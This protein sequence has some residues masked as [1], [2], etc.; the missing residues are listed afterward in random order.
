[1]LLIYYVKYLAGAQTL[2]DAHGTQTSSSAGEAAA[3]I[4]RLKINAAWRPR[5]VPPR[6][7]QRRDGIIIKRTRRSVYT[8]LACSV[9]TTISDSSLRR[10]RTLV[11]RRRA[12][13]RVF[14]RYTVCFKPGLALTL[15]IGS[16]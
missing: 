12:P 5:P 15:P 14:T 10:T 3:A 16:F 13:G 11:Y 2:A 7:R 1:M 4:R 9:Q 8:A 6:P